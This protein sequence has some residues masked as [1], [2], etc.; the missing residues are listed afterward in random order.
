MELLL[1]VQLDTTISTKNSS[2]LSLSPLLT[3]MSLDKTSPISLSNLVGMDTT[4][5]DP[6]SFVLAG[7]LQV[8]TT[9]LI[10]LV[11]LMALP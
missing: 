5:L 1:L 6:S 7:M 2:N 11:E 3:T 9:K 4:I 8:L 10:R